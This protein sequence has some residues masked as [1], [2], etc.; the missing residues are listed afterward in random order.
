M[1]EEN[2]RLKEKEKA[3][4]EQIELAFRNLLDYYLASKH[5]KRVEII[6]KE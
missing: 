3:E 4:E 6:T 2:V 5:S 1:M